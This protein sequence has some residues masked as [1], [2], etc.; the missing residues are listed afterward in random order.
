[1]INRSQALSQLNLPLLP[2]Q[3]LYG[4][5]QTQITKNTHQQMEPQCPTLPYLLESLEWLQQAPTLQS[6]LDNHTLSMPALD[7]TNQ[8][9]LHQWQ[10]STRHHSYL[11]LKVPPQ[12]SSDSAQSLP[13]SS[14]QC[15]EPTLPEHDVCFEDSV[16]FLFGTPSS[17]HLELRW[18]GRKTDLKIQNNFSL[19]Y[20]HDEDWSRTHRVTFA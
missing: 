16:W 4:S 15:S 12:H 2:L 7:T 11:S 13:A 19:C 10:A 20:V 1:M 14:F 5:S 18:V 6:K 3:D 17:S 8:L 9:L